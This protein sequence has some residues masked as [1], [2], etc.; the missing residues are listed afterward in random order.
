MHVLIQSIFDAH[1][2]E[3][4]VGT[5]HGLKLSPLQL[6]IKGILL[7]LLDNGRINCHGSF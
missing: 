2:V 5:L 3:E 7:I 4:V 1:V 6:L